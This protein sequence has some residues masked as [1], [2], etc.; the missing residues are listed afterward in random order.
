MGF[1]R[2]EYWSGLPFPSP[3]DL[4]N[5]GIEPMSPASPALAGKFFTTEPP[6]KPKLLNRQT[7]TN[8]PGA[9][10][11]GIFPN[12]QTSCRV[13]QMLAQSQEHVY[14]ED[15]GKINKPTDTQNKEDK[16]GNVT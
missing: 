16:G 10:D 12:T 5:A 6:E 11:L 8:P 7:K 13:G 2:Q 1:S 9:E 4:P 14:Q 15:T 3:G